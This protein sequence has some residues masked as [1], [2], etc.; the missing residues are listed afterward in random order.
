M[1]L[2]KKEKYCSHEE[3][4]LGNKFFPLEGK[5]NNFDRVASL[6][7]YHLP[8]I[9]QNGDGHVDT[10]AKLGKIKD[11][12]KAALRWSPRYAPVQRKNVCTINVQIEL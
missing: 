6:K 12:I 9:L 4:I 5:H 11:A 1:V 3:Q 2:L 8:L 7:V 10:S